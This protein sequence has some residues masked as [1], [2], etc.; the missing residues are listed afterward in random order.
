[1]RWERAVQDAEDK[2]ESARQTEI[3]QKTEIDNDETQMEKLKST[4]SA[5]K[6]EVDQ[7]EEEIGK[8]RREVGS[9]AKDIQAAQK[10]LNTIETKIEQRKAERHAILMQCKVRNYFEQFKLRSTEIT[11]NILIVLFTFVNPDGRHCDPYA[12]WKHGRH[13]GRDEHDEQRHKQ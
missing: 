13:S 4:R 5:K 2:L 9:I 11:K 8:C 7:K 12:P 6:M 3:N 1:M 10:Q